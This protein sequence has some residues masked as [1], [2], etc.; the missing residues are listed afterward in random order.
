MH[1]TIKLSHHGGIPHLLIYVPSLLGLCLMNPSFTIESCRLHRRFSQVNSD[2]VM[3]GF[4]ITLAAAA[5]AHNSKLDCMC[6]VLYLYIYI[7]ISS[8][9]WF[10]LFLC[11]YDICIYIYFISLMHR[12]NTLW[13][14]SGFRDVWSW[15]QKKKVAEGRISNFFVLHKMLERRSWC[16]LSGE[17]F[18]KSDMVP[19]ARTH[20]HTHTLQCHC[21]CLFVSHQTG[22]K[23][24]HG[25][26][27][28]DQDEQIYIQFS[29]AGLIWIFQWYWHWALWNHLNA[30]SNELVG[31]EP[32][33]YGC[34]VRDWIV[35]LPSLFDLLR[36]YHPRYSTRKN[37]RTSPQFDLWNFGNVHKLLHF[38]CFH[39]T[40]CN[41][42][43][44]LIWPCFF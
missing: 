23:D 12:Q 18:S 9:F 13:R 28:F 38:V 5:G 8:L 39:V 41:F 16:T 3:R 42:F 11:I 35:E 7:Y 10:F 21:Q 31:T 2:S 34:C 22:S 20:T 25:H 36:N 40:W 6:H 4:L 19:S 29:A 30:S 37:L 15:N 32:H 1:G 17:Q 26:I 44:L 27:M 33:R 43:L 14:L 24:R